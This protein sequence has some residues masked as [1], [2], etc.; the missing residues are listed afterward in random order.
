MA[1]TSVILPCRNEERNITNTVE[2]ILESFTKHEKDLEILIVNDGSTD[3]S[4][5]VL[6]TLRSKDA[7]VRYV[8]NGPPYG[9]GNAIKKGLDEFKGDYVI[10]AMADASDNPKDMV[11]YVNEMEKGFDCCFGTRWTKG[12]IVESYAMTKWMLNRFANWI[13]RI[14]FGIK[15]NDV[16]NAFKCYSKKTIEGI[17]PI[18][19]HHF[20]VTVEM[21]LKCITRGYTYSVV[22]T[23]WHGRKFGVSNLK[24]EEMGSRYL[25]IILYI[26]LEKMLS[27]GDYRKNQSRDDSEKDFSHI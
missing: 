17:Q 21:P 7:R 14:L 2:Q 10:I 23:S 4:I 3:Q 6:E 1:L 22:P 24:I 13:I 18:L 27:K 19:S 15:Y 12:A 5:N 9:I 16:T 25:F 20:N 26:W 8:N 11:R